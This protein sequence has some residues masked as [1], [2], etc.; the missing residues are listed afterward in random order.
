[1]GELFG[2]EH[3]VLERLL[4]AVLDV[5]CGGYCGWV[6]Q[7][8]ANVERAELVAPA[9]GHSANSKLRGG[10][11]GSVFKSSHPRTRGNIDD[12][13]LVLGLHAAG[14]FATDECGA[15]NVGVKNGF[16][17]RPRHFIHGTKE[18]DARVV[19][20]HVKSAPFAV[21]L[22]VHR[23]NVGLLARIIGQ[24]PGAQLSGH[25][26]EFAAVASGDGHASSALDEELGGGF[27]EARRASGDQNAGVGEFHG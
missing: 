10:V 23:H 5:E 14:G 3:V 13:A 2:A 19:D 6:H 27:S 12:V 20:E 8:H 1:M 9:F 16:E 17:V 21:D 22:G 11:D 26:F 18:S 7:H 4:F 24:C 15:K 25:L